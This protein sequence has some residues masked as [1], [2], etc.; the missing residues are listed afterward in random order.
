MLQCNGLQEFSHFIKT[1]RKCT[2]K[3]SS[4]WLPNRQTNLPKKRSRAHLVWPE[5]SH[6][7]VNLY[8]HR[9][10]WKVCKKIFFLALGFSKNNY[11]A[12]GSS[13]SQVDVMRSW[14]AGHVAFNSCFEDFPGI[15]QKVWGWK[16]KCRSSY[17][18]KVLLTNS[19]QI[20]ILSARVQRNSLHSKL[21]VYPKL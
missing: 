1:D 11:F 14:F 18:S 2:C 4:K 21:K 13:P 5:E 6:I 10:Q 15:K 8:T 17:W 7:T 3:R 16:R 20:L 9:I 12:C 19:Y